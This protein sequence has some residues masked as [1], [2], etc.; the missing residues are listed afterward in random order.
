[1]KTSPPRVAALIG[2]G[3]LALMLSQ[4]ASAAAQPYSSFSIRP[5]SGSEGFFVLEG[6][7]R[8]KLPA[9]V[10]IVNTGTKAGTVRLYAVDA[11][12][13]ATTGAVYLGREVRR[14]GVG[15]WI[16][17]PLSRL[18]L[19]PGQAR[20]VRFS[21][22]VPRKARPGHHLGGIV[23]E[24]LELTGRAKKGSQESGLQIRVRHLSIVAVQ[25]NLPGRKVAGIA[26]R[27]ATVGVSAGYEV[28]YLA[29][30]TSG[31]VLVRPRLDARVTSQKDGRVVARRSLQLDTFVPKTKISYPLYLL[32][33]P[34]PP[35]RYRLA[36]TLS[37]ARRVTRFSSLF[38]ISSKLVRQLPPASQPAPAQ[39]AQ[40]SLSASSPWV[41]GGAALVV[42]LV[43]GLLIV[44][45]RP[46]VGR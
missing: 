18:T 29:L 34:L 15:R 10:R 21:V 4:A 25:V 26:F 44:R 43:S 14:R 27:G 39:Q 12:T 9:T 30:R 16:K 3:L 41:I 42:G 37:Y 38:E 33:K 35:G 46:F 6:K 24:N 45:L 32:E 23:A 5:V 13:G 36:G 28:L 8:A 11:T 20:T 17:L 19:R 2:V 40:P 1:M 7:R 22:R 31:N